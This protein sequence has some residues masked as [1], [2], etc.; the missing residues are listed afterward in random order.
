MVKDKVLKILA[1]EAQ[2]P[3]DSL[4]M[5]HTLLVDLKI[6]GDDAWEVFESCHEQLNLDLQS[7]NFTDYFSPEPCYKGFLYI[8]RKIKYRDE[9]LA[10][11]KKTFTVA[12]LIDACERGSFEKLV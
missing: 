7:L 11:K 9:H 2:V 5:N 8:F 3:I 12:K 6:D 4:S 1:N 10:R